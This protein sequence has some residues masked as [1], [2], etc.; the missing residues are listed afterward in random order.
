MASLLERMNIPENSS[1]GPIRSKANQSSSRSTG[2]YVRS[3]KHRYSPT[4]PSFIRPNLRTVSR[5]YPR[6]TLTHHGPMIYTILALLQRGSMPNRPHQGLTL[7]PS[8]KKHSGM[9]LPQ[10]IPLGNYPSKV[11]AQHPKGTWLRLQAWWE[12]RRQR[13][14]QLFSNAVEISL[15]HRRTAMATTYESG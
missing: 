3:I 8:H 15:N 10:R 6:A 4:R 2:P 13:T 1:T 14:L 9:L 5:E 12:E 7:T 11:Q